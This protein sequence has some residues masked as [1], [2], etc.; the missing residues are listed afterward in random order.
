M[1]Q[2]YEGYDYAL[3]DRHAQTTMAKHIE[4]VEEAHFRNYAFPA[5]VEAKGNMVMNSSGRGLMWDVQY[6]IHEVKSNTGAN[7]LTFQPTNLWKKAYLTKGGFYAADQISESEVLENRGQEAIIPVMDGFM[8]RLETSLKEQLARQYWIDRTVS[9]NEPFWDGID[10]MF[11]TNGTINSTTGAQRTGNA[12]DLVGYPSA[13]YAGLSTVLGNY[14]GSMYDSA[15]FPD[16]D[17]DREFSFWSPLVVFGN[18]TNAY[19]TSATNT[20]A[21]Q[22]DTALRYGITHSKQWGAAEEHMSTIFL[23]RTMYLEAKNLLATKEEIQVQRG[24]ETSLVS[25]GFRDVFQIDGTEVTMENSLPSGYG[26]GLPVETIEYH[27]YYPSMIAPDG[28]WYDRQTQ[29]HNATCKTLGNLKF[30]SPRNYCMFVDLVA[31]L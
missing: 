14:G 7:R 5:Q 15:I 6:K 10:T 16:G 29:S 28:P 1:P 13:T 27:S 22:A 26:Y 25:L 20:W 24:D 18:S 2:R 4:G 3:F 17:S 9:G 11:G 21:G 30:M 23:A 8:R 19:H 31:K 12:A